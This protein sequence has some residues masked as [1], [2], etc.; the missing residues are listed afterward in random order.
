MSVVVIGQIG[1]DLV[2]RSSGLPTR[3]GSTDVVERREVLGGKGANQA[4]GL[5]QLGVPV[6]LIGVVGDDPPGASVLRQASEDGIDTTG[7]AQRGLTA[8]LVD[9]VDEPGSRR[10]FEDIPSS[11]LVVVEDLDR[12]AAVLDA[13]DT[14]SL[15]LQQPPDTVLTAARRARQ[16]GARVVADGAPDESIRDELMRLVDVIRADAKEAELLA[17][18]PVASVPAATAVADRLLGSGPELVAMAIPDAGNLLVWH[19][20][21]R[22][23]PLSEVPVLDPTGAGDAFV[24]GLIAGLRRGA[25]PERAGELAVAAA[26]AT[27][28]RLGGRPDLKSLTY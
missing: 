28:Q 13:A 8:L 21:S 3:G 5:A 27:V 4:V 11:S 15:Q 18:E 6:A 20:G 12:A 10:L 1:R 19:D 16:R 23:F 24:A 26:S 22:L 14:V 9:L 17:G 7:V 2:L 25:H